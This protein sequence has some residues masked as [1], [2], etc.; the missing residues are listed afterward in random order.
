MYRMLIVDDEN[1]I[2][3]GMQRAIARTELFETE[4]AFNGASACERIQ[5]GGIDAMLL[6]I[7]MPDMN[8]IELLQK[9]HESGISL[10]T[11][12]ISGYEEFDYAQLAMRYGAIDYIL[13]PISPADVSS[14]GQ[15][16]FDLLEEN[17][18]KARE[19]EALYQF[20]R[21]QRD[22][23]KQKMLSDILDGTIDSSRLDELR[24][25]YG[26]DLRGNYFTCALILICRIANTLSEM[27]FQVAL[28]R[29]GQEIERVLADVPG[30]NLF[31][32]E[33]ARYVL[34]IASAVPLDALKMEKLL[35]D[36]ARALAEIAGVE[37]FIGKGE[38][39]RG[40][41]HVCDSYHA[42]NS[43]IDLRAVFQSERIFII[44]DYRKNTAFNQ[45][46]RLIEAME[47]H[48]R[49]LDCDQA[50]AELTQLATLVLDNASFNE[51]QLSFIGCRI[52]STLMSVM[53]EN[54]VMLTESVMKELL[55]PGVRTAAQCARFC[56][57]AVAAFDMLR[58][59]I[60]KTYRDQNR[61]LSHRAADY[62]R[63]HFAEP[64]LSVNRIASEMNYSANYLG[65]A[66]K[67]E[68][69]ENIND[70]L[71]KYRVEQAKRLM[72]ES[73]MRVYE[74]AFAVGFNDQ[75]YFS[76]T[77]RRIAGVSPSEYREYADSMDTEH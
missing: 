12:I 55:F 16:L 43:A 29:A 69:G 35:S 14:I 33:N 74:I 22:V 8:G 72:N 56:A 48:A 23:I 41:E 24:R 1:L 4:I 39:V 53:L 20:V 10:P 68:Y 44:E 62:I 30:A 7:N 3:Q 28:R 76:R 45:A 46:Q 27:D 36:T 37:A 67:R 52:A 15:K 18:R 49:R 50:E 26:V 31:N 47:T 42:A 70:Y 77:F 54:D 34:L 71:N 9:L 65:N 19:N 64:N 13:K 17:A 32:M 25:L 2:A 59:D 60:P 75:H 6:D 5:A 73:D 38:Q 57:R 51:M 63:A 11:V 21:S 58:K 40:L 61:S 66:F